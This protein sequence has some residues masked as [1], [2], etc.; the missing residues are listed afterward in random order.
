MDR[1]INSTSL[2]TPCGELLLASFEGRLCLCDWTSSEK[3]EKHKDMLR[4]RLNA[5]F[6]GVTDPTKTSGE[7]L[8][9]GIRQLR[10]YFSSERTRFELPLLMIGS[11]FREE[12]WSALR[13]VEYGERLSY[14]EFA[15]RIG[16]DSAVRAVA[17]A[18]ADNPISILVPCHR[19]ISSSG[20]IGNYAG[21]RDAKRWLLDLETIAH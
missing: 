11:P 13:E 18:I 2:Q 10:Q 3:F 8:C 21:G 9:E 4:E 1:I 19:I 5:D 15:R 14:S 12:V 17:S 20:I 6:D 7:V 16:R